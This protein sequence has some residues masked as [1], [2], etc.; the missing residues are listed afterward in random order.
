MHKRAVAP[1]RCAISAHACKLCVSCRVGCRACRGA[2]AGPPARRLLGVQ[3]SERFLYGHGSAT[4]HVE[5]AA[6]QMAPAPM[7]ARAVLVV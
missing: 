3:V 2:S 6:A 5:G 7:P 1:L 4:L